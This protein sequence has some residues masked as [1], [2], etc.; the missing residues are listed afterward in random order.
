M[1]LNLDLYPASRPDSGF[2]LS[3]VYHLGWVSRQVSVCY[4]EMV[5]LV[6]AFRLDSACDLDLAL[7]L[8]GGYRLDLVFHLQSAFQGLGFLELVFHRD[9]AF[10]GLHLGSVFH[11][12]LVFL[13][14]ALISRLHAA[15]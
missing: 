5:H 14:L 2:H 8:S 4:L 9:L 13:A 6:L 10:P 1:V 3:L 12:R 15:A 7:R 11:L